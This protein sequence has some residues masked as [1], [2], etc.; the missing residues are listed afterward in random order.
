MDYGPGSKGPKSPL[1]L[2]AR[3]VFRSLESIFP[4]AYYVVRYQVAERQARKAYDSNART[5]WRA[6]FFEA[7]NAAASKSLQIGVLDGQDGKFGPNWVSVDKYD[8]RD[9][10]DHH[11]DIVAMHFADDTF[12]ALY[13]NAILEHVPEPTRAVA[14]F[15]RVLKPGATVW[16][17]VPMT[18][19]YHEAPKDY[20]RVTPDGLRMWMA[21]FEEI[22]CGL[23]YWSRSSL[24]CSAYFFGKKPNR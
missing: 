21:G 22:S 8:Q 9:F 17:E 5:K 1:K 3:R 15:L 11:D 10:I 6:A 18:Y 4:T 20:W 14:E 13:C 16:I 19:P 23:S 2:A 7:A 24:I 12:D